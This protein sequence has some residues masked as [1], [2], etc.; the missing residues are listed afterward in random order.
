MQ[1]LRNYYNITHTHYT[2]NSPN[3]Y[4]T[5]QRIANHNGKETVTYITTLPARK[6]NSNI[7][8]L[9]EIIS[10]PEITN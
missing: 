3:I 2:T 10:V 7:K 1:Y 4:H 8:L 9:I 6:T 5:R